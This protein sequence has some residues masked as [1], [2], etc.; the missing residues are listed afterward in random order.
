MH[1]KLC[2]YSSNDMLNASPIQNDYSD[3]SFVH[4]PWSKYMANRPQKVGNCTGL[5]YTPIHVPGSKLPLIPYNR[6]WETQPMSVGVYRA[7]L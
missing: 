7:P 3:F 1:I 2:S 6:G 5:K 4:T